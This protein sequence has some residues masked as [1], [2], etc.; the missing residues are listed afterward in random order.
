MP[1]SVAFL[2]ASIWSAITLKGYKLIQRIEIFSKG[3]GASNVIYMIW[4]FIFAGAFAA[5]AKASGAVDAT[6]DLA[7]SYLP[8]ALI[9]PGLFVASCFISMAIGTSVG[10]VVAITPLAVNIAVQTGGEIP[11]FVGIVLGGAFFGDNLSFISDTTIAATR[12]QNCNMKDKFRAN[13]RI[14]FPAAV[15][16]LI[17]YILSSPVIDSV[18][19]SSSLSRWLVLPY[20]IVIILALSGLNVIVVLLFGIISALL[21]GYFSGH[22]IIDMFSIAGEGISGVGD[23]I[24]VTLLA[25]GMLEMIRKAGGISF[26]LQI[27]NN[28]I[29]STRGAQ[30]SITLLVGLVNLCTANNTVAILTVGSLA[31]SIA[32]RFHVS[33]KKAASLLDTGSC[34]IQ[35]LIP[36][37]AQAMMAASIAGISPIAPLPYM[38]YSFFLIFT[39][40][41]SILIKKRNGS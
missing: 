30:L 19:I 37:G 29:G 9:V 36:Y 22:K 11:F 12:T 17:F 26:I 38:Y 1:L 2:I 35:S 20:L 24:V 31:K 16:A 14:V 4:I 21:G 28:N 33:S 34:I 25:A 3:A 13:F 39:L 27:I 18:D 32:D 10:T 15:M 40:G 7:L 5:I 6:V 23:L 41:I 8:S